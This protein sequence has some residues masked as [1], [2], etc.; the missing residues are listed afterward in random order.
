MRIIQAKNYE[1]IRDIV[2]WNMLKCQNNIFFRGTSKSLV[3]S[4]VEFF[5]LNNY[6]DITSKEN[7]LLRD[8]MN[9]SQ[10]KYED[11]NLIYNDWEKRISA[12]EH[13]LASSLMDWSNSMDISLEFSIH[14]FDKK[15]A[16]YTSLWILNSSNI[17]RITLHTK[18]QKKESFN[19]LIKP[20]LIQFPKYNLSPYLRRKFI[21]GGYFLFQSPL[22]VKTPLDKN[23]F[24]SER[25]IHIII[26]K[27]VVP[28]I[29]EHLSL[30]VNQDESICTTFG[31][32]SASALD[33]ICTEL[34][35]KY[36]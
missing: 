35:K 18:T 17:N 3:P 16:N 1:N 23:P 31:G 11:K 24:F 6:L 15:N 32:S 12:R 22:E 29:K 25:L 8:F 28:N 13:G 10:L 27:N 5:T 33:D 30:K 26:P 14:D 19:E 2:T 7:L 4:I 36:S 9:Y 20:T 21:Q 34:N